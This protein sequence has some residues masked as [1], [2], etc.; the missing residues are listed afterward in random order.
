MKKTPIITL[1]GPPG[2]GKGTQAQKII[3]YFDCVHVSTG[4]LCRAKTKE[5][6][7]LA[8]EVKS[9]IDKGAL[10]PDDIT[11]RLFEETIGKHPL[12]KGFV[13]DGFPRTINQIGAFE[14]FLEY[15]FPESSNTIIFLRVEHEELIHRINKR[16]KEGRIDDSIS[17]FKDRLDVFNQQTAPV[18]DYYCNF[19]VVHTIVGTGKTP[20]EV[21]DEIKTIING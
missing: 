1:F 2:S 18:I 19:N 15:R 6:D 7:A 20:D 16:S 8:L 10:V 4:D 12:A 11:I 13:F 9:F 21:W 14:N 5:T 3:E 17:V